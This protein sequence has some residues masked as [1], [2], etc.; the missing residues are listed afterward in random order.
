MPELN[1][2]SLIRYKNFNEKTFYDKIIISMMKDTKNI[3]KKTLFMSA[4][5]TVT[6]LEQD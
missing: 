5:L 2:I 4:N 3:D 1:L 6:I